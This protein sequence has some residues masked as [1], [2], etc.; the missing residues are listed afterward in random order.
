MD[1]STISNYSNVTAT[2]SATE[3]GELVHD[4]LWAAILRW[5]IG[6]II[7]I[8]GSVGNVMVCAVVF[9]NQRMQTAMNL[10][11]VNL[12]VWDILVCLFNIPF[13]LIYNH[14]KSWPFGLFWCKTMPTLQVMNLSASTGSLV[15]ITIERYRAICLPFTPPLSKF[16][17]KLIIAI[18]S[19]ASF[20]VAL[21]EVGAYKLGQPFGCIEQFPS[22]QLRKAYSLL[23]FLACY[24]LPLLFIA[25]AYTR[26]ILRLWHDRDDFPSGGVTEDPKSH[27]RKRNVLKMMVSVVVCYAIC[28]L[29]TYALFL[30]LDFGLTGNTPSY[31]FTLLSFTQIMNFFNSC[32]NP[33]IYWCLSEQFSKEFRK[34][35]GCN[36]FNNFTRHH[37][38]TTSSEPNVPSNVNHNTVPTKVWCAISINF[39]GIRSASTLV[40]I[41]R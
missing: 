30:W 13:T 36:K 1:P 33:I 5:V 38:S 20:L 37:S 4:P 27:K 21:P 18:V 9:K 25:P 22:V 12:A 3:P 34:L 2:P 15:A 14:L 17:A 16:Q 39:G 6:G 8:V 11:L 24:L 29:P 26:M 10:F 41:L 35:L 31:F 19:M 40:Y 7:I 28:M 23:L 32:V